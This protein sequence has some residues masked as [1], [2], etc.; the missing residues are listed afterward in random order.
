MPAKPFNT[1]AVNTVARAGLAACEVDNFNGENWPFYA[2]T[3]PLE[4]K[5]LLMSE[6]ATRRVDNRGRPLGLS[7]IDVRNAYFNGIPK[8]QLY[9]FF[10]KELG[11][12][13]GTVAHLRRCVYGTR[14]A[15]MIWEECY[16]T[17]LVSMGVQA[18]HSQPLLLL[19]SQ[20]TD[21]PRRPWGRL[22]SAWSQSRP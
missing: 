12:P 16:A 5:R 13:K 4:A 2:A 3:P 21:L 18:K 14:D 1:Y 20:Q 22:H 15:G 17:A 7:F 11:M 10:P 9:L 8:R 19:S 6:R